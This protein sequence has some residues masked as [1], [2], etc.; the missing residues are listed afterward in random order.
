MTMVE[1]ASARVFMI[2]PSCKH[3]VSSA[4]EYGDVTVLLPSCRFGDQWRDEFGDEIINACE[5]YVYNPERDYILCAGPMM[6]LVMAV[7]LMT[8]HYDDCAFI[9]LLFWNTKTERFS[10][11]KL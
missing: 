7:C 5:D 11:V 2:E 9:Q 1:E 3:D 6:S 8:S 10:V 4:K